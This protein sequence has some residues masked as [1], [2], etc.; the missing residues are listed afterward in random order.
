MI[1]NYSFT[2]KQIFNWPQQDNHI[3]RYAASLLLKLLTLHLL[4]NI[5]CVTLKQ[6]L[7]H[8]EKR[9]TLRSHKKISKFV[10]ALELEQ[11]EEEFNFS[12]MWESNSYHYKTWKI[13]TSGVNTVSIYFHSL[14]PS[15]S[16]YFSYSTIY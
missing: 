8:A 11:K 9:W 7:F 15:L 1:R 6:H 10:V 2:I 3:Y 5:F 12:H 14:S 16:L 13:Y 4:Y